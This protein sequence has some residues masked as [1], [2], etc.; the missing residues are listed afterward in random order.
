VQ[1]GSRSSVT[2]GDP[3]PIFL[4]GAPRSGT[5]WI[6]KIFDS[7]PAILYR[8]EPDTVI[9]DPE[10]RGLFEPEDY[11]RLAPRAAAYMHALVAAR[12]VKSSGSRPHFP[13][14]FRSVAGNAAHAGLVLSLRA[15]ELAVGARA[16]RPLSV[17]DLLRPGAAP[18]TVIKTVNSRGR[19]G[20]FAHAWPGARFVLLLRDPVG[21]IGSWLHGM[22]SGRMPPPQDL[23]DCTAS[24]QARRYG[25][26]REAFLRLDIVE[27]L[28][29]HWALMNEK[30]HDDLRDVPGT[31]VVRL[32]DVV[33]EPA[34]QVRHL[35][36][37]TGVAWSDQTQRFLLASTRAPAVERYFQVYR[38]SRQVLTKWHTRLRAD[39]RRRIGLALAGTA[40]FRL[41]PEVAEMLLSLPG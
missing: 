8:H 10:L 23:A 18:V 41:F 24:E 38:D 11:S 16:L 9:K 2:S 7:S 4:I 3:A 31:I 26:T 6:A 20:L 13:K 29:W 5:T 39:D 15:A 34:A 36:A 19:A 40:M 33:A 37:A 14:A 1:N 21:Q 35:F 27:Q 28:A 32:S 17:P 30:A 22:H 12:D 25:I